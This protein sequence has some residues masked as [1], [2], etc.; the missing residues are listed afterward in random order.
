MFP[1]SYNIPEWISQSNN[2]H[3]RSLRNIESKVKNDNQNRS[4]KSRKKWALDVVREACQDM[5]RHVCPTLLLSWMRVEINHSLQDILEYVN[6]AIDFIWNTIFGSDFGDKLVCGYIRMY[7]EKNRIPSDVILVIKDIYGCCSIKNGYDLCPFQFDLS[8]ALGRPFERKYNDD[9]EDDDDDDD[10]D[11][12][13]DEEK[14]KDHFIDYI[15]DIQT[16]LDK[17][18]LNNANIK[19]FGFLR[20]RISRFTE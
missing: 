14:E 10:D 19:R 16:K 4:N 12:D 13:E 18:N 8:F 9:P 15:G 7:N 3:L 17:N 1:T 20:I 6:A 11:D 2:K 5:L